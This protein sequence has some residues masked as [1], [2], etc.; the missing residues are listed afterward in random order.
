MKT[1]NFLRAL[2]ALAC[3]TAT[4]IAAP[5]IEKIEPLAIVPGARTILTFSGGGL[6]S[7]SNLWTSFPAEV[8]RARNT[9]DNQISF[10]VRC[11]ADTSGIQAVQL[12]G[13]DGASAFKLIMIDYLKVAPNDGKNRQ[14][15]NALQITPPIA[16]DGVL[17][18]EQVDYYNF[19]SNAGQSHS[20]EVLAHRLGS[21]M[22]PA[23]RVLNGAG[24]VHAC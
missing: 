22:D 10:A 14:R 19:E 8:E 6:D 4:I 18:S 24:P 5:R 9:N 17:K 20:I 7:V 15:E 16:L 1:R 11:P 2:W 12:I 21:E 13:A 3:F 23:V